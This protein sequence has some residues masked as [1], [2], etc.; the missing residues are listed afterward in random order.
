VSAPIPKARSQKA[1]F[2]SVDGQWAIRSNAYDFRVAPLKSN[3]EM[4]VI[5][6]EKDDFALPAGRY[7][8]I[9][10]GQAYDFSIDGQITE[11]AQC[12][13]RADTLNGPVYSECRNPR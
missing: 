9:L 13:E 10:K 12:V 4:I 1:K 5:K 6:P 11:P 2:A 3:P 7:A 8:L